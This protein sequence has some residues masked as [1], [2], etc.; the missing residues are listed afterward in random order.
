MSAPQCA[1]CHK[2]LK[3]L[4]Y[5]MYVPNIGDKPAFYHPMAGYTC[6]NTVLG[7][8]ILEIVRRRPAVLF[9]H[10]GAKEEIDVW[11]GTYETYYGY[12]CRVKCAA[13]YGRDAARRKGVGRT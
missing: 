9:K 8:P 5:T 13:E 6:D 10:M 4:T 7:K 2:S 1:Q 12:F 11:L 3:R